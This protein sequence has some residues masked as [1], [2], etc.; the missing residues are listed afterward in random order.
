MKAY[1]RLVRITVTAVMVI[2]VLLASSTA[3][4]AEERSPA[5]TWVGMYTC[6]Q[7]LTGLQLDIA[8]GE[9]N[10]LDATF[11]SMPSTATRTYPPE[12]SQC[13]ARTLMRAST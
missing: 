3:A 9:G 12:S 6:R 10:S 11:S 1:R 2:G 8:A 13:G 5:G 4:S 7:G